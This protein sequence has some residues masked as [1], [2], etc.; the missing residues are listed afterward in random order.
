MNCFLLDDD[1]Y[2]REV[3]A[4]MPV[5]LAQGRGWDLPDHRCIWDWIQHNLRAHAIQFSKGKAKEKK[6]DK[7]NILQDE[8]NNAKQ[9]FECDPTDKNASDFNTAKEKLEHSYEEKL[10]GIIIRARAQWCE[11]SEYEIFSRSGE[12][13][14]VD[15][16]DEAPLGI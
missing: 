4:K 3:T 6:K 5:W 7:E 14:P 13:E 16:G 1:N 8:F 12:K 2:Q 11:H 15:S 9:T 10:Q